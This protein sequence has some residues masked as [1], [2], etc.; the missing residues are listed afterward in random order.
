MM[1]LYLGTVEANIKMDLTETSVDS[2]HPP[3]A[4]SQV[5]F[6]INQRPTLK[7]DTSTNSLKTSK[8]TSSLH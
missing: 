8:N 2:I 1:T 5:Q 7:K 4:R 6:V 3:Q